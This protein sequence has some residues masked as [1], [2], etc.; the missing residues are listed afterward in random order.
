MVSILSRRAIRRGAFTSIGA[1][2]RAIQR[3]LDSWN[4]DCKPFV[5][6]KTAEEILATLHRQR[7]RE[8]VHQ[9]PYRSCGPTRCF[10]PVRAATCWHRGRADN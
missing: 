7:S 1:L 10:G 9:H 2:I 5:W 6:V 4:D 8:T 3:I